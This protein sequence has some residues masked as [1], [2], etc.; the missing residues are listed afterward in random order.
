LR[1]AYSDIEDDDKALDTIATEYKSVYFKD[2][3]PNVPNDGTPLGSGG[4]AV[5]KEE[6]KS[7]KDLFAFKK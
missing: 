3:V 7:Y 2:V 4:S 1:S 6:V 5:K